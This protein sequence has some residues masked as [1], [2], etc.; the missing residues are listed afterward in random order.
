MEDF[1]GGRP[2][3]AFGFGAAGT[4]DLP[5]NLGGLGL[6]QSSIDL[7]GG[8]G[9]LR[10]AVEI[11]N[12]L[13]PKTEPF[14][15]NLAALLFFTKMGAEAAKPGATA[16]GAASVGAQEP[17][18]YLMQKRKDERAAKAAVGPLTIQLATLL[19]KGKTTK[20]Y[21]D[22]DKPGETYRLTEAAA[23]SHPRASRLREYK[24][25][26]DKAPGSTLGKLYLDLGN[27]PEGSA[28]A[29]ALQAE[30]DAEITKSGFDKELFD[31]ENKIYAEFTKAT[32]SILDSRIS[33]SKM[34]S[35]REQKNGPGDLAM[36][37]S[38]MKMLDPGSVVRE[39]EF[40]AAQNTA[41]LYEKLLVQYEKAKKGD[42]LTDAQRTNFLN[43][44]KKF[45]E[46]GE[47]HMRAIRRNKGLQATAS[48]LQ[49][50]LDMSLHPRLGI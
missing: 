35:A 46:S 18:K 29:V 33:Y 34:V 26:P 37:F 8:Q 23:A 32:T 28:Q 1:P 9:N 50:F 39:S 21:E 14:D 49:I 44:S 31:A 12:K 7:L 13:T 19:D 20:L 5:A 15:P 48:I 25:K 36:I 17:L 11:A 22:I 3:E 38:F 24:A 27:A 47:E 45:L 2:L 16:L 41:G 42:L 43:L 40:S 10:A 6:S 4:K 30:I